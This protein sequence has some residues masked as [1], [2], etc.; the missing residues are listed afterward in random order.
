M[1]VSLLES[2]EFCN[3]VNSGLSTL[4]RPV[5]MNALYQLR[6]CL[7]RCVFILQQGVFIN[8]YISHIVFNALQCKYGERAT[9]LSRKEAHM[10][11][12]YFHIPL[13]FP[14]LILTI[15]IIFNI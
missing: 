5:L 12:E 9:H 1:F 8:R 7:D 4:C 3:P 15:N 13:R 6:C 14:E 10:G 11:I 2:A